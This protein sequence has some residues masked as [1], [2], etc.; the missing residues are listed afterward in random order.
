MS[1]NSN[2][3][4]NIYNYD[5][6]SVQD[7]WNSGLVGLKEELGTHIFEAFLKPLQFKDYNNETNEIY[8]TAP[9]SFIQKH[10]ETR[11]ES[12]IIRSVINKG[13]Q[14]GVKIKYKLDKS[15]F[16][17]STPN[18][19]IKKS[20]G[21]TEKKQSELSFASNLNNKYNFSNLVEGENNELAVK[22]AK[23]ISLLGGDI[24]PFY[25]YGNA[26]LGKTHILNA[27]GN[28]ALKINPKLKIV[29]TSAE[30]FTNEMIFFLK[31]GRI[32]E[33]KDKY[34]NLDIL[35]FDDVQFLV[36]KEKTQEEFFHTFNALKDC[37]NNKNIKIVVSGDRLPKDIIGLEDKLKTRLAWG[38][39]AKISN[40]DK[41][42]RISIVQ[43][44]VNDFGIKIDFSTVCFVAENITTNVRELEGAINRIRTF[45]SLR[46]ED[47][48]LELAKSALSDILSKKNTNISIDD[49]KKAVSFYFKIKASDI[50][51]KRRTKNIS[52][53][54]QVAMFLSRKHTANSFL[55]IGLNF[56]DR[57][58]SSVIHSV[59]LV[60]ERVASDLIL[61]ETIKKIEESLTVK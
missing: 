58:H 24:N 38:I 31:N 60:S 15:S 40:P 55:E 28:N 14:A 59:N 36:N 41:S 53:A 42:T 45:A 19:I 56:G 37:A 3:F 48:N 18:I 51:S 6:T 16:A 4:K 30:N 26:G 44:K 50:I 39:S 20:L 57:D 49:I 33:F 52:H 13:L 35:L 25:V 23:E 5:H 61:S 46:N 7:I 1:D 22:I 10:I 47:I 11:Y 2:S 8:I 27:I 32:S 17:S 34:R 9:S 21:V 43:K 54:R 12:R 29:Y